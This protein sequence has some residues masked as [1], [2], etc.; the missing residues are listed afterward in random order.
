MHAKIKSPSVAAQKKNAKFAQH[1]N[2]LKAYTEHPK[3]ILID[4]ANFF[5]Q[6]KGFAVTKTTSQSIRNL[7]QSVILY[8][9]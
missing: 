4:L 7:I 3:H 6:S 2:S 5:S 8:N 1:I 9:H